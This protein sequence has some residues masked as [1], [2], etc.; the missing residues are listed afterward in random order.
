MATLIYVLAE[1]LGEFE[2]PS[3]LQQY[4]PVI[5]MRSR[6]I[7]LK[8]E[9]KFFVQV[10]CNLSRL[11]CKSHMIITSYHE[12]DEKEEIT[13]IKHDQCEKQDKIVNGYL[14]LCIYY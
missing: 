1:F 3:H 13:N 5:S 12:D 2:D 11:S 7:N 9:I 8:E 4:P 14:M 10:Y 6:I